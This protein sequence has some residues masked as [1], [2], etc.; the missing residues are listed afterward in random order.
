MTDTVPEAGTATLTPVALRVAGVS[1]SFG[2][3]RAVR[4]VSLQFGAGKVTALLGENGAGKSTMIRICSGIM[5]PDV[6]EVLL[7]GRAVNWRSP[8]EGM[9]AGVVVVNQEPQLV[10]ELSVADNIYLT[11][12]AERSGFARAD[13]R[14]VVRK[15]RELLDR[16][17]MADYLP[18]P[19]TICRK[20]SAAERQMIDIVRALSHDPKVLFLD[21]PNSSLTHQETERL[22]E[23]IRRMRSTGVAVVLV[24]HR[25]AEVYE[26]A[27]HVIVLR[28]GE[29]IADGHPNEITSKRAVELMAGAKKMAEAVALE[30]G[31][32]SEITAAPKFEAR[33]LSGDGFEDVSFIV[34]PGEIVGMAGL[35]GAGRSE[36]A[37]GVIGL[38]RSTSGEILLDGKP[39]LPSGPRQAQRLGI[40]Y[41]AEERRTEVFHVQSVGYNITARILDNIAKFGFIGRGRLNRIASDLA[42]RFG[43]KSASIDAPI[44]SLSGGN[45]QKVLLARALATKPR[46]LILD[47]PT[48]GVDVGTKAEIYGLLR[49]L[50]RTEG[51]AVWFISS[52]MEEVIELADRIIVIRHGRVVRDEPNTSDPNPVV[53][54]AMGATQG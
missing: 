29:F 47:E 50:A 24:S 5:Q 39:I 18:T 4:D 26:I 36:I 48:R 23:V 12:L 34:R 28:D 33:N 27:D 1:K 3:V 15:A 8:L 11:E 42:S 32:L 31:H 51:L 41:V 22:F 52:E 54:A 19:E 9:T 30:K 13:R 35:I 2:A 25:L 6:G 45:Q 37:A 16:L 53:A 40:S 43:V 38:T 10:S 49:Q 7:E 46:L 20:L 44:T 14:K 17:G 21:E